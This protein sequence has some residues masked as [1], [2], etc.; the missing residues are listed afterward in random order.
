MSCLGIARHGGLLPRC[1]E[2]SR[3]RSPHCS[4]RRKPGARSPCLCCVPILRELVRD[5]TLSAPRRLG[6]LWGRHASGGSPSALVRP[7]VFV[8]A[9]SI[10]PM[11]A[12][13]TRGFGG[14]E[15]HGGPR[16]APAPHDCSDRRTGDRPD[17]LETTCGRAAPGP[18]PSRGGV[19]GAPL[20]ASRRTCYLVD[21]ASSHM[22]VSKIKPCMCKYELIQTVKLR[23]AH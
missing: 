13:S 4:L 6:G 22:L 12:Q 8:P 1:S 3:R 19:P 7:G 17:P 14:W 9:R 2:P 23:M 21:P 18:S 10:G 5:G 16:S 11:G 20:F 15:R